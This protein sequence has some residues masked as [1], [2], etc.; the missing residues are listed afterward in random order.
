[1]EARKLSDKIKAENG[2]GNAK[3]VDNHENILQAL[4][5]MGYDEAAQYVYGMNYGEWKKRHAKKASDVQMEKF[6]N[7]K[8]VWASH[9]K[10]VLAKRVDTPPKVAM[11]IPNK[12]GEDAPGTATGQKS[13]LLSN[14]CCQDVDSDKPPQSTDTPTPSQ[15]KPKKKTRTLPPYKPPAP[16][17]GIS[18]SLGVLTISD[19]ASSGQYETGDLSGPA[20][21]DAVEEA[22]VSYNNSSTSNPIITSSIQMAIVPDEV[23][24]IESKLK[25][26]SDRENLN[27]IL[28]TG[29]TGFSPRDVTPE[30]TSNVIERSCEGLVTFCTMECAKIQPLASLSRGTAGT[31]GK[32]LIINLPG[33]PKGV[34]EIIP[35]LLPLALTAIAD[36]QA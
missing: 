3:K 4:D 8:S 29:G 17:S 13:S 30:A 1:M 15:E 7:S 2:D 27:L 35:V 23:V 26:W 33:N 5:A 11:G 10:Q 28:T 16:P 9:D 25:D 31:R 21:K 18:F 32:S 22:I 24:E 12:N 34:G 6:N 14:V 20:V 36:I 19:R